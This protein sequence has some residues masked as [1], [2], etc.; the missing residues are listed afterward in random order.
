MAIY[1]LA[2][3]ISYEN[4]PYSYDFSSINSHM[5]AVVIRLEWSSWDEV[6]DVQ[7]AVSWSIEGAVS[8]SLPD[9]DFGNYLP[10][11]IGEPDSLSLGTDLLGYGG[12]LEV[13]DYWKKTSERWRSGNP[14]ADPFFNNVKMMSVFFYM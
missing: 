10:V 5:D 9:I 11:E 2:D 14:Y 4:V 13:N 1:Q 7:N 8:G 3:A 6:N 12:G